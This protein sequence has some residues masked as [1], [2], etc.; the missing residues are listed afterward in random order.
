[1]MISPSS[2][3]N[4]EKLRNTLRK[5]NYSFSLFKREKVQTPHKNSNPLGNKIIGWIHPRATN[6]IKT[7][8]WNV[9]E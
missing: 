5:K 6:E 9:L 8:N 2:R 4:P 7:K 3:S 1:M